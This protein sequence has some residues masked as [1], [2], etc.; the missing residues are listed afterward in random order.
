MRWVAT[1]S[2]PSVI[3]CHS[4]S[5]TFY[6]PFHHQPLTQQ[7]QIFGEFR[8]Q[9]SGIRLACIAARSPVTQAT[10]GTGRLAHSLTHSLGPPLITF[11]PAGPLGNS[12]LYRA[13]GS[14]NNTAVCYFNFRSRQTHANIM[15]P[16]L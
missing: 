14:S 6:N 1:N 5:V 13:G 7:R 10:F 9:L 3:H 15:T 2:I 8:L 4:P 11:A 12:K 16:L